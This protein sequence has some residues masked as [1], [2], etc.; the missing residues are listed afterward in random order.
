MNERQLEFTAFVPGQRLDKL[1]VEHLPD[2]SRAQIQ[3]LI[4]SGAVLVDGQP[5]KPG[6]KLKGGEQILVTLVEQDEETPITPESIDLTVVYE[7]E[8]LAVIDKPAG[9]VVHPA[10]GNESGT[11][12]NAI[13]ARWPQIA[14]MNDPDKRMGLVHRLDKGTSGLIVIAKTSEALQELMRQFQEREVDKTYIALLERTPPTATGRIEAPIA[15]DPKQRKRMAVQRDGKPAI[16]E[17]TVIDD[18]FRDGQALVEVKLLTGRTHQIRVHMAFIG[19]PVV[20]DT[21]YGFRKQRIKMKRQFLHA[22]QL[23]F[24]HPIT[25]ERLCVESE[26]PSGLQNILSKLR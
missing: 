16:T 10:A 21:V 12:V 3:T 9:M 5:A 24:T 17:Y 25:G 19:C 7:D 20:G 8:V 1:L 15:R 14:E 23:C 6:I 22:A 13:L 2:I 26:L 11:L 4:K 18:D